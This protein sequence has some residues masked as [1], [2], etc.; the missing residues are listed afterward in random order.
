MNKSK[1]RGAQTPAPAPAAGDSA[2]AKSIIHGKLDSVKQFWKTPKLRIFIL[3]LSI[4][5]LALALLPALGFDAWPVRLLSFLTFAQGGMYGGVWGALGGIIGKAVFAYSVSAL[6]LPLLSGGKPFHGVRDGFRG[7]LSGPAAPGA[8]RTAPFLL[9][10]G[11]ALVVF[12]FLTG[13]AS[14]VNS[15][16]GVI[17]L[18]LS[19]RSVGSGGNS[20]KW[21]LRPLLDRLSKGGVPAPLI[22]RRILLGYAGGS[23]AGIALS[24]FRISFLPYALGGLLMAAGFILG[25]AAGPKK[26]AANV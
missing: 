11:T 9:G 19:L 12:N 7:V 22:I 13:N 1:R 16:A 20:I 25:L 6:L 26:E 3:A 23:A 18:S 2:S 24:F 14:T 10:A 8:G 5:W 4:V 21:L 15:M 17:G